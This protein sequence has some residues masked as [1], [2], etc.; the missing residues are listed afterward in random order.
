MVN[1]SQSVISKINHNLDIVTLIQEYVSL[2]QKGND[3]VG[4]CPFHDD[5]NPSFFVSDSK[6]IYKCFSCQAGGTKFSFLRNYKHLTWPENIK[7]LGELCGVE[8]DHYL[9]SSL[10]EISQDHQEI[11]DFINCFTSF[12]LNQIRSEQQQKV[13][14]Y[15]TRRGITDHDI[16][17]FRIG[18]IP[19]SA[20]TQLFS[21]LK[22][23]DI[24]LT[25]G[26]KCGLLKQQGE[27]W[28]VMMTNRI[29]FPIQDENGYFVAVA[30]RTWRDDDLRPK[31]LNS[32]NSIV[33]TKGDVLFNFHRAQEQT[34]L[35]STLMVVEGYMD[36]LA[37][38]RLG[39]QNTVGLMGTSLSGKQVMLI[40]KH[41]KTVCLFLDRDEP[42]I[43]ASFTLTQTLW[44]SNLDVRIV[45]TS[46]GKDPD[47][48]V[49]EQPN[50]VAKVLSAASEPWPWFERYFQ[51]K[52]P[53]LKN[54]QQYE[55]FV[56]QMTALLSSLPKSKQTT[57]DFLTNDLHDKYHIS[58]EAVKLQIANHIANRKK[59]I[60]AQHHASKP[61]D[62]SKPED[63]LRVDVVY[64]K[65]RFLHNRFAKGEAYILL[66]SL[67]NRKCWA[68]M[69]ASGVKYLFF[70]P[71]QR[72][73]QK[74][75]TFYE[76]TSRSNLL[77]ENDQQ[78]L[79]KS[80]LV[81]HEIKM[82]Q[83]LLLLPREVQTLNEACSHL[84]NLYYEYETFEEER[85]LQHERNQGPYDPERIAIY[86]KRIYQLKK[87]RSSQNRLKYH[88]VFK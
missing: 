81:I 80:D 38:S 45:N 78:A 86:S 15:L 29:L 47:D 58:K 36:V 6:Q 42:G 32:P 87:K 7:K 31:Y 79:F 23:N 52:Y 14:A 35:S 50:Q 56:K 48:L 27:H 33:F 30:G 41:F 66:L 18:Y 25:I 85:T 28:E 43:H 54:L 60:Y 71:H 82:L 44:Q 26:V 61:P 3:W 10:P 22:A 68:K 2:Q 51:K 9:N 73:F 88:L 62:K 4:L 69:M 70:Q 34:G 84:V 17:A 20:Q 19:A 46:F 77:A 24:K 11:Y 74:I 63:R 16:L 59:N 8:V 64:I 1:D 13:R 57:I 72:I 76:T 67:A 37:L 39:Y 53:D 21:L 49:R 5:T 55:A 83:Y 40:K 65:K 75:T 12:A